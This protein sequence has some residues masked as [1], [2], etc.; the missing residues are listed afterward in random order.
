MLHR[1]AVG[2]PYNP[3]VRQW[4]DSNQYNY[5]AGQHELVTFMLTPDAAEIKAYREGRFE[6][7]LQTFEDLVVLGFQPGR[8]EWQDAVFSWHLV[9]EAEQQIPD[10]TGGEE[11]AILN[12]SLVDGATGIIKV[13]RAVTFSPR[14]TAELHRAIQEQASKPFPGQAEYDRQIERLY[15]RFKSSAQLVQGA[16]ARC[17]GGS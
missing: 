6:F 4:P 8:L 5:R 7:V 3:N 17:V 12:V 15:V 9:P 11:R 1:Y 2:E 16:R 14:F 13:L 10:L